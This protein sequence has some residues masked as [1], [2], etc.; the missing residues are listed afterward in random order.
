M[1]AALLLGACGAK[2]KT[3]PAVENE[4][5]VAAKTKAPAKDCQA[6]Q[7]LPDGPTLP[8]IVACQE[9]SGEDQRTITLERDGAVLWSE[10]HEDLAQTNYVVPGT[11][12]EFQL[13]VS[14]DDK[15]YVINFELGA[16]GT[17]TETDRFEDSGD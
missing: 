17:V 3:R 1:V 16:D 15:L 2:A 6:I 8:G 10:E 7:Q 11:P 14:D 9:P 12:A 13:S 5:D 4:N